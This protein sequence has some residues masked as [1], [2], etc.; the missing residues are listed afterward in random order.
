MIITSISCAN[1]YSITNTL[2][3]LVAY[4]NKEIEYDELILYLYF[5]ENE[6][7]KG[8]YFLNEEYKNMIKTQTLFRWTALENSGNERKIKYHYKKSFDKNYQEDK[9]KIKILN[10]YIHIKFYRFIKY[11]NEKCELGLTAKEYTYLFNIFDLIYK[12]SINPND[13]TDELNTIFNKLEGL[14]KKRLLKLITEFNYPIYNAIKPFF[15]ELIKSGDKLFSDILLKRFINII[16]NMPKDKP[17]TS[18][19]FYCCDISTNFSSIIKRI[20]DGYEY[21]II[22]I[23]EFNIETLRLNSDVNSEDYNNYI[24]FFK[25]QNK[26]ISFLIYELNINE[27]NNMNNNINTYKN[28]IFYKLL[29]RILTKDNDEPVKLYK[30]IG[31]PSFKYYIGMEKYNLP[32]NKIADYEV[33]DGNDWFNFCIENNNKELL[34]SLPE[35]QIINEDIKIINNSFI[36]AIINPELTVDYQIPA[37][38]IY[39]INKNCWNKT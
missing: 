4:C 15:E 36:I 3:Q 27:E 23:D 13:K 10:N 14:K 26:S 33:L 29:K 1:N 21:N 30:K 38:N 37:L 31:I 34:F 18:L 20:L 8:E 5:Y 7:K 17:F 28:K 12:Y 6:N 39:Y 16:Q 22:A 2:L 24:Y 9:N 32:E 35:G 11:N 19:G 25:S